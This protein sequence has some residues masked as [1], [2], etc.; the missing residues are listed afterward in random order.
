[1]PNYGWP[2]PKPTQW[3]DTMAVARY[4]ALP[5][6]L[7]NLA[8]VL[9]FEN[10]DAAGGRLISKYSKLY[11]KTA[12]E[13]IPE[14]DFQKFV[15][16]CIQ[17][18]KIEQSVSDFLGDLPG[19]ELPIFQLDQRINMRGLYLDVAGITKASVI[20]QQRAAEL[21]KEFVELTGCTPSQT[22]V[23]KK[24]FSEQGLELENMQSEYLKDLLESG[25]I[26]D[27]PSRRALQIRTAISKASTK[28]LDAMARQVGKDGTAKFQTVYHGAATGRWTGSGFQPL[29]LSR[30]FE[31]VD[32]E[33]LVRDIGHGDASYLDMMYG[34]AMDA[35]GK[36]SRH[37][38]TARPGHDIISGDFTSIEAII[39]ACLSGEQWK[40]DA[41]DSGVPI[42]ELTAD[43]IY[44]LPAGTVTKKTHPVERQDGKTCELAFGYQGALGA[45]LKFDNS[46]RHSDE[47]IIEICKAWRAEHPNVTAFW[48]NL[49][50]S[51]IAAT[52][53]EPSVQV[54]QIKFE[55]VDQWL[56]MVLPNEKRVW[57]YDPQVRLV[58]PRWCQPATDDKC[59]EGTCKHS[60]VPALSYMSQKEG[61]W[62]RVWTYGGKLAENACQAVSREVLVPAMMRAEE[63]GYPVIL[64]VYDE[65]VSEVPGDFGDVEEFR[66]LMN[67]PLPDWAADWPIRVDTPW[68]GKRYKK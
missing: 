52:R 68:R 4:Y 20:V 64:S 42:Y 12:K 48:A 63:A 27:G 13:E 30:G 50:Q 19:R 18:V 23:A 29:N 28:K 5:G 39:L 31:G 24:W 34:D 41:F 8:R 36:A 65:I 10:K 3:R 25:D 44:K 62:K 61:Q 17:D 2:E 60:K 43:K 51:A 45:W 56:T 1:M 67:G 11:L 55:V 47:R 58:R 32:P 40:V 35:I 49:Q 33:Q 6:G 53:G 26:P 37:W 21:T 9:G 59:R 7:A 54:G 16:Y 14:D 57:Y 46:G 22:A 38:V 66:E 15:E